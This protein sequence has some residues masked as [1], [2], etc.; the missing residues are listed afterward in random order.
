VAIFHLSVKCLSR[1]K[2]HSAV[3][4]A[5]YRAGARLLDARTG[6]LADY[7][8]RRGVVA[9]RL[10]LPAGAPALDRQNL[11]DAAEAAENRKNSTVARECEL[12]LP[13]E[14]PRPA[15]VQLA[16]D[17]AA[18]LVERYGVAVDAAVH[19]PTGDNDERNVHAHLL[20]TTRVLDAGGFGAKTRVLDAAA[21]GSLEVTT[22]REHWA[23]LCNTALE[24]HGYA[25][26]VDHRSHDTRG[27]EGLPT[28]KVGKWSGSADRKEHNAE[29]R[30]LNH[31]L[32]E[33][34][35]ERAAAA[36]AQ[37]VAAADQAA[38]DQAERLNAWFEEKPAGQ[39]QAQAEADDLAD[40]RALADYHAA[41]QRRAGV[42][43]YASQVQ[44]WRSQAEDR[45]RVLSVQAA[46]LPTASE[47]KRARAQLE[48]ARRSADQA[49]RALARA[50][51]AAKASRWWNPISVYRALVAHREMPAIEHRAGALS[52][53]LELI[54]AA[55]RSEHTREDAQ[56]RIHELRQ[57]LHDNPVPVVPAPPVLR[58]REAG[59]QVEVELPPPQDETQAYDRPLG[60]N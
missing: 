20:M 23:G 13:A 38:R 19:E 22:W 59:Q 21:T 26:R 56:Q 54:D 15:Q 48:T 10:H 35:A 57:Q 51:R 34:L 29:V 16:N 31:D 17:L 55:A 2:G 32:A 30:A 49:Q 14:L 25:A 12:A 37:K 33:A 40:E 44:A 47:R 4:A 36:A 45:L 7:T 60:L 50:T 24:A 8:R 1:S 41:V 53:A 18:W 9:T 43:K 27:L 58:G 11:W 46:S 28:I 6:E 3:V 52:H 5:A 39:A 42:E